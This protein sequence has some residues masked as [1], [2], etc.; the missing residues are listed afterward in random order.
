MTEKSTLAGRV[1][2]KLRDWVAAEAV[3]KLTSLGALILSGVVLSV[4]KALGGLTEF[5]R[6]VGVGVASLA[7]LES[8]VLFFI[9]LVVFLRRRSA[10]AEIGALVA[11]ARSLVRETRIVYGGALSGL[12][13]SARIGHQPQ[14]VLGILGRFQGLLVEARRFT[15]RRKLFEAVKDLEEALREAERP[16]WSSLEPHIDRLQAWADFA[17]RELLLKPR[18]SSDPID[19]PLDQ[20]LN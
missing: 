11:G 9:G 10:E 13:L 7:F 16:D 14:D 17:D 2:D 5:R 15:K 3:L 20:P 6:G 18:S 1:G 19:Q 8:M 12:A 4:T